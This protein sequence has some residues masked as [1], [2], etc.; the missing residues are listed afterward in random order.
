MHRFLIAAENKIME[1]YWEE[2]IH[3]FL[4]FAKKNEDIILFIHDFYTF[5]DDFQPQNNNE[6]ENN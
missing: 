2:K 5:S 1:T 3:L 4:G 6:N